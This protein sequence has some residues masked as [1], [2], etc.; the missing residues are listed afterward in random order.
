[1]IASC[2]RLH[3]LLRP[4]LS[5]PF[6]GFSVT[7]AQGNWTTAIKD[8]HISLLIICHTAQNAPEWTAFCYSLPL[9]SIPTPDHI[10]I[11][12]T[13]ILDAID[14]EYLSQLCVIDQFRFRTRRWVFNDHCRGKGWCNSRSSYNRRRRGTRRLYL[15]LL[16]Q[17]PL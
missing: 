14:Q 17:Q 11:F 3:V 7:F 2:W 15:L 12:F 16:L 4:N 6:P 9:R 13:R 8:K 10:R 1:M 5:I